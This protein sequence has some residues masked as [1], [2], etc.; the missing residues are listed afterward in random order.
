LTSPIV[1]RADGDRAMG[2]GHVMRMFALAESAPS[3]FVAARLDEAL[4]QRLATVGAR[5]ER[6][7]V[8]PGS[9]EDAAQT[10]AIAEHVGAK[11]ICSDGYDF[12]EAYQLA[13]AASSS[14]HLLV[15]DYGH[16][17]SYAADL[18]LNANAYA[19]ASIYANRSAGT[20]LL[21]GPKYTLLRREFL[22]TKPTPIPGRVLVTMGGADPVDATAWVLDALARIDVD[23]EVIVGPANRR[24]Y[25]GGD[26]VRIVG[27]VQDMA[28]RMAE[29]SLAIAAAGT[30]T[31][32]LCHLG[33]PT[34]LTVLADNQVRVAEALDAGGAAV[35]VGWHRA[36][37]AARLAD[38]VRALLDDEARRSALG[39]AARVLV[40]GRGVERVMMALSDG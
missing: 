37:D 31:Y 6:I 11:W 13:V 3:V 18:V 23:A 2:T 36:Y 27:P 38:T 34:I 7:E 4:A 8:E 20:Q 35:N 5:V 29:A 1:I 32:E 24:T 22:A 16:A 39:A 17:D 10:T 28:P 9:V 15:D 21:L 19:D 12:G 14:R 30:T 26:G 33:V 40:D 25:E